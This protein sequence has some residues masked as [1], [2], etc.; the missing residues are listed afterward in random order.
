MRPA[1]LLTLLVCFAAFCTISSAAPKIT[2]TTDMADQAVTASPGRWLDVVVRVDPDGDPIKGPGL[3]VGIRA[4]KGVEA[5]DPLTP[6]GTGKPIGGLQSYDRPFE[7]RVPVRLT[8]EGDQIKVEIILEGVQEQAGAFQINGKASVSVFPEGGGQLSGK[9]RLKHTPAVAGEANALVLELSIPFEYHVYGKKVPTDIGLPMS[10]TL[11]RGADKGSWSGSVYIPPEKEYAGEFTLEMP[12]TPLS[13]G[14][15]KG[16]VRLFWQACT[17]SFCDPNAITYL[18]VEFD[19]K[20][21][22][23]PLPHP[24]T[25]DTGGA[26]AEPVPADGDD[27]DQN[28]LWQ[29]VLAGTAAGLFALVMPCTYPL[30]PITI[31]FFTKQAQQRGGKVLPLSL[32]YGGGIAG[33]FTAIG[34]I[35]GLGFVAGGDVLDIATS[36]W[37]NGLFAILFLLFGLSLVGLFEI[38]LPGFFSDI[39]AKTSGTGGYLSVFAMGTTLVITSFTCTA[40]FVGTLLV[41][42]GEGGNTAAATVSMAAF[43]LTMAIPFVLL[44][45]FPTVLEKMPSSGEWMKTLK[46]TLGI[47]ELGLVLKFVSNIDLGLFTPPYIGRDLFLVLWSISFLTGGL[48]LLG[49]LALLQ[50]GAK[51]SLTRGRAIA[52]AFMLVVTF[53]LWSG[54]G[55]GDAPGTPLR[56]ANLEAFLPPNAE[57]GK[58]F[59]KVVEEDY[60]EGVRVATAQGAPIFLHY[61]GYQ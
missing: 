16:R 38:R 41:W 58:A 51:W 55:W 2:V 20:K 22:K 19:V 32:A 28:P 17:E 56:V 3:R 24:P 48:Y 54:I 39:A 60:E 18:P 26:V 21:G 29:L 12:F 25:N 35:V 14:P 33:I 57:Y 34:V 49:V 53:Y 11:V 47:L 6:F 45:L 50:K 40:P 43:G 46:V 4:A 44:S 8:G 10:A 59:L 15:F 42:A 36:P 9:A 1:L 30:I 5:G 23:R 37:I 13:D 31:S 7:I 61:T 27:L 52:G